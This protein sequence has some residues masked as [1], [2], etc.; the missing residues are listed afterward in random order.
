VLDFA[1]ISD[2]FVRFAV[3]SSVIATATTALLFL[4]VIVL[5]LR[6]QSERRARAKFTEH[7]RPLLTGFAINGIEPSADAELLGLGELDARTREFLLNDWNVLQDSVK[8]SARNHLVRTGYRLGLDRIAHD[9]LRERGTLS[10]ELLAVVT[11]GHLGE[12]SAWD[13]IA[14]RLDSP[15]PLLSLMAAKALCNIDPN[16]AI[17]LVIERVLRRDDWAGA[18]V[19]GVLAEAGAAAISGPLCEAILSG[20]PEEQAKLIGYLPMVYKP[21]ASRV[22]QRLLAEPQTGDRVLGACL[23]VA[24]G[25]LELPQVRVLTQHPRWHIRMRAAIALG[26]TG[27]REDCDLLIGLL[28]DPEWWVRRRAAEALVAMPFFDRSEL[29]ALRDGLTDRFGRDSLDQALAEV[30]LQ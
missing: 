7:W 14:E 8:G 10:E 18:R 11:L 26:R 30:A 16:S 28:S 23:K 3:L 2:P 13:D 25:P 5:R 21:Y 27:S 15:S 29:Y 6:L 1:A 4:S 9:L 19:A 12:S 17:G 22:V 24:D 20:T